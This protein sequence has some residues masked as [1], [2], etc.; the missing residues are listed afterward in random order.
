MFQN[1]YSF[2]TQKKTIDSLNKY[3]SNSNSYCFTISHLAHIYFVY[4]HLKNNKLPI[5]FISPKNAV[6]YMGVRWWISLNDTY[7][8]FFQNPTQ[9]ILDCYDN[10]GL[11][12]AALRLGQKK[13]IFS[14]NSNQFQLINARAVSIQSTVI[15]IRP[16][17]VDLT[18]LKFSYL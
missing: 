4:S 13:I 2:I 17:N 5:T 14:K 9:N 6:A 18:H 8:Y 7:Q 16:E 1:K 3:F 11:A 15:T 10:A 12:M